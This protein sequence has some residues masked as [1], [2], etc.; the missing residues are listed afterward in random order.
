MDI[1][2]LI[3]DARRASRGALDE[4]TGKQ[5]LASCGIAV[6]KSVVVAGAD[7]VPAAIGGLTLP[8]V[9]K[10]VSPEILH[11]SDAGGVCV[12]LATPEAVRDAVADMAEAPKIK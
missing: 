10:V 5:V 12:N 4:E 6:P 11:K 3:A 2:K 9:V 7:D 1:R 8:V